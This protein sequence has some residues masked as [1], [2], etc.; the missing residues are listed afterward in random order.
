MNDGLSSGHG[1]FE[2]PSLA[3]VLQATGNRSKAQGLN[4]R[5][6]LGL[7]VHTWEQQMGQWMGSSGEGGA[8]GIKRREGLR[9]N[10][11]DINTQEKAE[12]WIGGHKGD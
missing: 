9:P 2:V 12:E 5:L 6:D 4:R 11:K 7:S 10:S 1:G 8:H 3:V